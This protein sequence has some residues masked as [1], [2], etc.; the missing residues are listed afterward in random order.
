SHYPGI[1][2]GHNVKIGEN[3]SIKPDVTIGLRGHFDE[4][5]IQIGNNVTIGCNASI[6]GGKVYI[7][8]NVTIGAHA[9]VL[10][11]I[12]ENSIFINKIEYEIITKKVIAEM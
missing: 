5:D 6:L 9:L 8:D 7:G 10:H 2:I 4:M 3:C 11:D 12:P 1:V